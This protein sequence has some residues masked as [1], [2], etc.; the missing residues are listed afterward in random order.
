MIYGKVSLLELAELHDE[1]GLPQFF[2]LPW[3]QDGY[4]VGAVTGF[5]NYDEAG[6]YLDVEHMIVSPRAHRKFRVMMEM[7]EHA[8]QAAFHEGCQSVRLTIFTNNPRRSGLK[9][10]AKRLGYELYAS[11]YDADFYA[12]YRPATKGSSDGQ[13]V[14]S[15]AAAVSSSA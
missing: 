1:M 2:V 10:W 9:A 8:T 13:E 15:E 11:T 4:L 6:K 3:R 5:V 7:S 12:R 14:S